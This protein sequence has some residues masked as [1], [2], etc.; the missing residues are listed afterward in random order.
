[1]ACS[2]ECAWR[3]SVVAKTRRPAYCGLPRGRQAGDAARATSRTASDE[4]VY[5]RDPVRAMAQRLRHGLLGLAAERIHRQAGVAVAGHEASQP[6]VGAPGWLGVSSTGPSTA[7]S[8]PRSRACV[9]WALSCA[10]APTSAPSGSAGRASRWAASARAGAPSASFHQAAGWKLLTSRRARR[11]QRCFT[12]S[13]ASCSEAAPG[14]SGHCGSR[15]CTSF[16][17]RASAASS[18]PRKAGRRARADGTDAVAGRQ[19]QPAQRRQRGGQEVAD[20]GRARRVD[21]FQ[22]LVLQAARL[23]FPA[24]DVAERQPYRGVG[25][26]VHIGDPGARLRDADADFFLQFARQRLQHGLAGLQLAAGQFPPARPGLA[27]GTLPQQQLAVR[28][29]DQ[30]GGDIDDFSD[31]TGSPVAG[32]W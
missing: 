5:S 4:S 1:M 20:L 29:Q 10:D 28:A 11:R 9:T 26:D 31:M 15:S 22:A 6:S 7:K 23:A 24:G 14:P 2:S 12:C 13:S 17:P 8:A 27:F 18:R 3:T 25:I 30:A 19:L 16:T 21:P 32:E